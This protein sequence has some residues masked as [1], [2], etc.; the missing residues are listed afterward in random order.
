MNVP[1]T[2]ADLAWRASSHQRRN[3]GSVSLCANLAPNRWRRRRDAVLARARQTRAWHRQMRAL[4]EAVARQE[5]AVVRAK[6]DAKR[7]R[8]AA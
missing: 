7:Q 3:V 6:R 4:R 1:A 5:R 2:R 8:A